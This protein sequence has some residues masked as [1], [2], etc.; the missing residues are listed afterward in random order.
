MS[1]YSIKR[2]LLALGA[3]AVIIIAHRYGIQKFIT[4]DYITDHRDYIIHTIHERY[5]FS[6]ICFIGIYATLVIC[7]LPLTILMTLLAGYFFSIFLGALY[8]LIGAV[9]GCAISFLMVRYIIA[10]FLMKRYR[11]TFLNFNTKFQKHGVSYLLSLELLPITPFPVINV[12][13]GLSGVPLW[14]FLATLVV[15][16]FPS[17]LAYSFAGSHLLDIHS[18]SEVLSLPIMA[19]LFLLALLSLLPIILR[20]FKLIH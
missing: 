16:I 3:I 4:L 10:D 8:S 11:D 6:V 14:K 19:S 18:I 13:A 1:L 20:S 15:G 2:I 12:L 5:F 7:M 17:T 9:I